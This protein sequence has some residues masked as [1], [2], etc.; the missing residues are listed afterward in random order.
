MISLPYGGAALGT[1]TAESATRRLERVGRERFERDLP[2]AS[3]AWRTYGILF[4]IVEPRAANNNWLVLV[5][6]SQKNGDRLHAATA[7]SP[8][9]GEA[10][11]LRPS[12][13]LRRS[14][15]RT[16]GPKE[17]M[18]SSRIMRVIL[19]HCV[20]RVGACSSE[21]CVGGVGPRGQIVQSRQ[22]LTGPC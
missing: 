2:L 19:A 22:P 12:L 9:A 14:R 15:R 18:I 1:V 13:P 3:A 17:L 5:W 6:V 8:H 7:C 20:S 10:R 11:P 16:G 21:R 4:V